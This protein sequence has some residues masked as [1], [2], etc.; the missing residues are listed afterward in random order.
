[1]KKLLLLDA[2]VIIDLHA[3]GLFDTVANAYALKVVREV[4]KEAKYYKK[5]NSRILINISGK[6]AI[7]ENISVECLQKVV[8]EAQ[9]AGLAMDQ[10]ETESIAYLLQDEEDATLCTC[11]AA[12]IKCIAYMQ[13]E[14]K[15]VSLES[16]LRTSGH[17]RGRRL[18][19]RHLESTFRKNQNDGKALRV[20]RK[21]LF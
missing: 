18:L 20:Q 5:G 11:D 15:P 2:D 21:K 16:V 19:P 12:G 17:Y 8:V 9:E 1:M 7:I 14:H 4:F 3:F 13:L 6:V 10:G